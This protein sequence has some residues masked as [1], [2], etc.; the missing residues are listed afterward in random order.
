M[1][2]SSL[3]IKTALC[4]M[5]CVLL[6][7]SSS[8]GCVLIGDISGDCQVSITDLSLMASQWLGSDLAN[9]DG[10]G[11][12]LNRDDITSYSRDHYNWNASTPTAGY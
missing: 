12:S 9:L 6:F 4:F 3:L 11:D 10:G 1:K 8:Q 2:K 7:S 5:G